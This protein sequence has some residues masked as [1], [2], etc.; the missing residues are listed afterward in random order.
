MVASN[1]PARNGPRIIAVTNP[2]CTDCE[3]SNVF[4]MI[5]QMSICEVSF[6]M[7]L[8]LW[9]VAH[10]IFNLD[11]CPQN[12]LVC[13]FMQEVVF[14]IPQ[15]KD[16]KSDKTSSYLAATTGIIKFSESM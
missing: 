1:P 2:A 11:F 16:K 15:E 7:G 3:E 5:E 10:Y 8:L 4:L 12:A 6:T 9:F 13:R 14:Q